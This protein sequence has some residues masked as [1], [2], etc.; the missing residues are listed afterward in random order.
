MLVY[1]GLRCFKTVATATSRGARCGSTAAGMDPAPYP[2]VSIRGDAL[3]S[4]VGDHSWGHEG[5]QNAGEE[6]REG[7]WRE[8]MEAN[9]GP[10]EITSAV[11]KQCPDGVRDLVDE[12][13]TLNRIEIE[14][15]CRHLQNR[16]AITDEMKWSMPLKGE[17]GY[18]DGK[19]VSFAGGSDTAGGAAATEAEKKDSYDLKINSFVDGSKIKI[20]KEVRTA[21][22]VGLKEAKE[23]VDGIPNVVKK[24][25]T[26]DEADALLK[27]IT[28]AGGIAELV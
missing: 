14:V 27:V 20:I 22:G 15:F 26:K 28:D 2:R 8:R 6:L 12:I 4:M 16:L 13:L 19:S 23:L 11:Y 24:G 3:P 25:M 21:T 18:G 1:R 9:G 10:R 17:P 5:L 7:S